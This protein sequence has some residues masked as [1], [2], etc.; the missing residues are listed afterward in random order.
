MRRI[1]P[2]VV[3]AAAGA[4]CAPP[5]NLL[6]V[7]DLDRPTDVAFMCFGAFEPA[8]KANDG[9]ADGG[10]ADGG[11]AD[12]GTADGG[13]PVPRVSGRPMRSCHPPTLWD[14][15]ASATSRTFA[16]MVDS[17]SGG[18]T[19]V[20]AD[21]WKLVDLIPATGGYGQLPLGELPQQISVS[22][23]GCRLLS[24]NRG[25]CDLT[26]VDPS[27][28]VAPVIQQQNDPSVVPPGSRTATATIRPIKGDGTLL[29]ASPYEAVFLPQDTRGLDGA[30]QLCGG[31]GEL[32]Q[33]GPV[34]WMTPAA[35]PVP[36]Y[37]LVTYPSC[38]LIVLIELPSGKIVQS[39]HVKG[40]TTGPNPTVSFED[41]G[42]SPVCQNTDCVGQSVRFP[43]A[44]ASVAD[45]G[46]DAVSGVAP[47]AGQPTIVDAGID[48][49][50]SATVDAGL[51][52]AGAGG[53]PTG[54]DSGL[55]SPDAGALPTGAFPGIQLPDVANVGSP[56]GPSS[57]AIVPNGSRVYV[58]LSNASYVGS[59]GLSASGLALPGNAIKLHEGANGSDRIRLNVD[60]YRYKSGFPADPAYTGPIYSGEF[61]GADEGVTPQP[62]FEYL[63][64][65]AK[66]GTLRVVQVFNPGAEQECETN[67]DP[68][69]LA[70]GTSATTA[71]IP[72]DPTHAHRRPFSV[73]PGIHFPSIPIDVAA[74][75]IRTAGAIDTSEQ[76]VNGAHAWVMTSSGI[77][78]LVNIDPV[79]RVYEGP[80]QS[81]GYATPTAPNIPEQR[82]FENTLRDRNEIT[83]SLT[84]DPSSGPPRVDVLPSVPPT[85]PYIESFWTQGAAI[86]PTALTI[87]Y[88]RTDVF[89][90]ME[91]SPS[92]PDDPIDRRAVTPQS[93]TVTWEGSLSGTR[94]TGQV[95]VDPGVPLPAAAAGLGPRSLLFQ[96]GGGNFCGQGVLPGDLVTLTG[97]TVDSQCGLGEAC[98]S[99]TT[100][101]TAAGGVPVTGLCVDANREDAQDANCSR[102]LNSVRRY[103]V[104]VASPTQLVLQPNL[105]EVV[106]SSLTPCQVATDCPDPN[107]PTT[108]KFTCEATY[109]GTHGPSTNG[110]GRC[111]MKGCRT[112]SDCRIGRNC[113]DFVGTGAD[114]HACDDGHCFCA[115]APP[116]D[117]QPAEQGVAS[118][119][120]QLVAY[121]VSLGGSFLVF[122]S[123]SGV[124]ATAPTLADGSCSLDPTPDPR[125]TFRIPMSAPRCTN[126]PDVS[127]IDSRLDPDTVADVAAQQRVVS[128]TLL[129]KTLVQTPPNPD[130]CL[131]IG[132]P[133]GTE[134]LVDPTVVPPVP[135]PKHVRALF[136]NSQLSFVLANLDRQPTGQLQTGFDVHGGFAPQVVQ[137]PSTVEVS[138]PAR[139]VLGPVDSQ[140]Q[141]VGSSQSTVE[142]PYLFVVDQRRLGRAQG[143]GPTRGQLL[144]IHP[145]GFT[146]SVGIAT[147]LQP[148][149]Q[150]YT[151]SGGVFPIQ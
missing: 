77:V 134:P 150:D 75:D 64:V 115:D 19:M 83:Y 118:C 1:G 42:T 117:A 35:T 149:F 49:A 51:D 32:A 125:F 90:P 93:W 102:F 16:F 80:V 41:A 84:L 52:G 4:A 112:D 92:S 110:P 34:G 130:P 21:N 120:D 136:R 140:T 31:P 57:I 13:L 87:D 97:C 108:N 98:L 103:Q 10:A 39:V 137:D 74:A 37:A 25:S 12:A 3:L 7:N 146:S 131:Y 15:P 109:P 63:Y 48:A 81:N 9:A 55:G 28:L 50:G 147:G 62:D 33:A 127:A 105:D 121:Q 124:L 78:Y 89:F 85:G 2:L 17:A 76:S 107:D 6:P 151:A 122:G 40:N 148:I 14:P 123:Q 59:F 119:F 36:W 22:D 111:L 101:T 66:D 54:T 133:V 71:C 8:A 67:A 56:V 11:A 18:L 143:G 86:N 73:G 38:D 60:P 43:D 29:T 95:V 20:D 46:P 116:L 26:L 104:V 70:P 44:S 141:V 126:T 79:L 5:P 142:I 24:A 144:R 65:I 58:S 100:V 72:I 128:D 27:V 99:D 45:S 138:M 145:L 139:I 94:N 53:A 91:P 82:P 106:L 23:D 135:A 132:G 47:D 96:D 88:A 113:V 129:L 61:I 68:L 30:S 69:N 114:P